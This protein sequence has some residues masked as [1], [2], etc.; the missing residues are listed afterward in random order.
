MPD[1][2]SGISSGALRRL[3]DA[4]RTG[5]ID[6]D[7]TAFSLAKAADPP[8]ALIDAVLRLKADGM[9]PAHQA[10]LLDAYAVAAESR[11]GHVDAELVWTGPEAG[12]ARSR[13][14]G[15]VVRELFT[16]A[17]HDVIVSTFVVHQAAAVFRPLADRMN[18]VC[19][20]RVR[21]FLHVGRG[22]H[23]TTL[24]SELLREFAEKLGHEWPSG[25]RPEVYYDPRGLL[26]DGD[27]RATWHAKCV[28]IDEDFAFVTSANFTEWAQERNVEAGVV[29]KNKEFVR[30]IRHQFESLIEGKLVRRLPGF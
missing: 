4:F 12:V 15:V 6:S 20:L 10:L 16:A 29:I 28:V 22:R 13:D 9:A 11:A 19:D 7:F 27:H 23:D 21:L 30:Q 26:E 17:R 18:D 8:Q 5:R 25:R 14:T 1:L 3:A 24:D 2:F